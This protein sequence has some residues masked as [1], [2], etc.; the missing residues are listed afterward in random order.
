MTK[1]SDSDI[2]FKPLTHS[3]SNYGLNA[4]SVLVTGD[5]AVGGKAEKL[6]ALVKTEKTKISMLDTVIYAAEKRL[7]R[8]RGG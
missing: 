3:F 5:K 6:L 4:Y 2:Q 8:T 1:T 7:G